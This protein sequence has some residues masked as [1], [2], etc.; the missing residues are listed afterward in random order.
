MHR[1]FAYDHFIHGC[2]RRAGAAGLNGASWSQGAL[3]VSFGAETKGHI[4]PPKGRWDALSL[5]TQTRRVEG[6]GRARKEKTREGNKINHLPGVRKS[7]LK[8]NGRQ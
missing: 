6:Q 3:E 5:D 4:W 2:W 1:G 8:R 7:S